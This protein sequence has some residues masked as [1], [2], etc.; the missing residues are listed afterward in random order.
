MKSFSQPR[1]SRPST[2]RV[3]PR[4]LIVGYTLAKAVRRG[5]C[6]LMVIPA[7]S[8]DHRSRFT[9]GM[10][11]TVRAHAAGPAWA[12]VLVVEAARCELRDVLSFPNAKL[13]GVRTPSDLRDAV[14]ALHGP[15]KDDRECWVL[16]V[17]LDVTEA[18]RLLAAGG[19]E[20]GGFREGEDRRWVYV[21]PAGR[22][23]EDHGY[24]SSPGRA[25]PG[26]PEAL[27]EG[28]YRRFVEASKDLTHEQWIA[29]GRAREQEAIGRAH[30]DRG[31]RFGRAR[32]A[33]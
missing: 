7:R 13:A 9:P 2:S 31:R 16:H 10:G 32:K 28:D 18:P 26:E 24:T 11:L 8:R 14:E 4:D 1:R 19:G 20:Q 27:S 25:L 15:V 5:A 6:M 12:N 3:Q 17:L 30:A 23:D 21:P 29:L 22:G 33:A